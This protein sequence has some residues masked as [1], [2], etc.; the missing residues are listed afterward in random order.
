MVRPV[1]ILTRIENWIAR[2]GWTIFRFC[3]VAAFAILVFIMVWGEVMDDQRA[4]TWDERP[5]WDAAYVLT[6][7]PWSKIAFFDTSGVRCAVLLDR[8][9]EP[10]SI[11]CVPS[12]VTAEKP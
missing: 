4:P 3:V 2:H 11:S 8:R 1:E 7:S 10:V 12:T 6:V 5:P 9:G